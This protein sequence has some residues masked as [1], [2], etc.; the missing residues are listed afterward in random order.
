M[1]SNP[2]NDDNDD[3]NDNVNNVDTSP[4]ADAINEAE[5]EWLWGESV[6]AYDTL[7]MY[8]LGLTPDRAVWL[9]ETAL[10]TAGVNSQAAACEVGFVF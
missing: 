2:L 8:E 9:S 5:D 10:L 4:T 6:R 7:A 3:D 1:S